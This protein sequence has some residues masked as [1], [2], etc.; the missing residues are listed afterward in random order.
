M[1][2]GSRSSPEY[3]LS[4]DTTSM[5]NRML[6]GSFSQPQLVNAVAGAGGGG[7][8]YSF[9]GNIVLGDIG[10]RTDGQVMRLVQKGIMEAFRSL[11][12]ES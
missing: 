2:H 5:L 3:V 12:G 4:P 6:G 10:N 1:L 9:N 8:S 11:A 7:N